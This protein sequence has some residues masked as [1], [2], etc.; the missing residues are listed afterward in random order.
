MLTP[1]SSAHTCPLF[2]TRLATWA[3]VCGEALARGTRVGVQRVAAHCLNATVALHPD[4]ARLILA[5][6]PQVS[7]WH[8]GFSG[9]VLALPQVR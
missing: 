1:L 7:A 4:L 8:V 9:L 6:L 5:T 2:N 3:Q